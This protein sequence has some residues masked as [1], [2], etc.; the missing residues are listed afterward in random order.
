MRSTQGQA[1]TILETLTVY[2]AHPKDRNTGIT[3]LTPPT[4]STF[5]K[6]KEPPVLERG[7]A[8]SKIQARWT[9]VGKLYP[10][11]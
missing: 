1:N 3:L 10:E 2:L 11:T 6:N 4:S 9:A 5:R 8:F 7:S